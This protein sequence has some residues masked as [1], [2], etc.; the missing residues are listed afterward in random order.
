MPSSKI[1]PA[2]STFLFKRI[3]FPRDHNKPDA[4]AS[5]EAWDGEANKIIDGH[6][7]V[8]YKGVGTIC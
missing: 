3:S 2:N 4:Y 5:S 6:G 8:S 7:F 1:S